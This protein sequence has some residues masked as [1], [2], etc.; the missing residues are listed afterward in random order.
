MSLSKRLSRPAALTGLALVAL[1]M[2]WIGYQPSFVQI[3]EWKTVDWRFR[4][5]GDVEL[6]SDEIVVVEIDEASI[7]FL[8][9]SVGRWPWPRD[10]Y[11]E[12]LYYMQEAG[13]KLV[14][15]DIQFHEQDRNNPE[16][17]RLFAEATGEIGNVIHSVTPLTQQTD[18]TPPRSPVEGRTPFRHRAVFQ[19]IPESISP[20]KAWLKT[21]WPWAISGWPSTRTDRFAGTRCS[22]NSRDG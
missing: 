21:L 7:R 8:E 1:A 10:V 3:L 11:S 12:F 2:T 14:V 22:P 20:L 6:A 13:A 18:Y 5:L 4:L 17:D 16:G 9:S 15:F 19:L